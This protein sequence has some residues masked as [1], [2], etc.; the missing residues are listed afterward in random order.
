MVSRALMAVWT[1]LDACLLAAGGVAV[2]FAMIWRKP[3]IMMNMVISDGN[4][5]SGL[6]LGI[7]LL[8]TFAFSVGAIVQRNH[9]TIGL[10]ILN[11]LLIIDALGV[12]IIG[13]FV[14]IYTLRERDNFHDVYS[15]VPQSTRV[16][17][18]DKFS[19]CGYFNGSDLVEPS[20][21]CNPT[22]ISFINALDPSDVNNSKMFCV[23]P[24]TAFADVTLNDIFTTIYGFM[25]IAICLLLATLCVINMRKEDERFKRID[26]KR[27]GRGF[28]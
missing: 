21:F 11:Y 26:A 9:V 20:N 14:W 10:V 23:T 16:F 7:V 19:C 6:I 15:K 28:V 12:L 18:Q 4:L 25:A 2:A 3:D 5:T 1:F 22:Q 17:I 27:G 13:T 8:I 24:I